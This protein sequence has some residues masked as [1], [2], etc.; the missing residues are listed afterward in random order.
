MSHPWNPPRFSVAPMMD[1]T[2][3][4]FRYLVRRISR[5]ALLYTEMVTADAVVH[6]DRQRLLGFDPCEHP[7]VLQLGGSDPATMAAAARIG[8]AAGYDAININVGCPSDRVRSGRFGA[9]LML[10]PARVAEIYARMADAVSVPVTVKHRIGVDDRD[11]YEHMLEFVDTVASA[12]CRHFTIHA[13]KA[14]L[15][16][17]SPKQNRTIPPLRHAEVHRLKRERPH[18]WIETNG[19]IQDV[20]QAAEHL[21]HVDAVMV[22]RAVYD[23]PLRFSSVDHVLFGD[24]MREVDLFHVL[25]EMDA[26]A[27]RFAGSPEEVRRIARHV[28]GLVT[29]RRGARAFRRILGEHAFG[30]DPKPD[31]IGRAAFALARIG[32]RR[33]VVEAC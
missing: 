2:D 18:L 29:G 22:G 5:R 14:W 31:A 10:E 19:G 15:S 16:G 1:R 7:V 3:R 25:A 32:G 11:R 12:G 20:A 30:P 23:D 8:E 13:R 9:C 21:A 24:P 4:H 33:A 6:G 27:R 26:Y 17:L 28:M